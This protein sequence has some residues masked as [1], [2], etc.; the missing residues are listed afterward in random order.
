[1]RITSARVS[2]QRGSVKLRFKSMFNAT[3][4]ECALTRFSRAATPPPHFKR[5]NSPKT[6][7]HLVPFGDYVF[8][9]FAVSPEGP[10]P[11]AERRV[12]VP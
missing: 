10:G 3:G 1:V 4:F 12:V 11:I 6:Y 2:T 9:V 7:N 8:E 5:C